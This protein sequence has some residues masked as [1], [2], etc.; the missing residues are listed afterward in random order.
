VREN[1]QPM[2][3]LPLHWTGSNRF[4]LVSMGT[5]LAAAPGQ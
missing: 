2:P 4:S 1:T 5:P 3:N